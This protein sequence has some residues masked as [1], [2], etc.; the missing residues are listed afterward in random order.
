M[1]EPNTDERDAL[2]ALIESDGWA[3]FLKEI[4]ATWGDAACM[5][6]ID[7]ALAAIPR[8]DQDAVTDTVQQIRAAARAVQQVAQWPV[9]RL[10]QLKPKAKAD[11]GFFARRRA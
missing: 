9:L 3:R 4:E 6:H 11:V 7:R 8:G 2:K 5:A 10:E 1:S